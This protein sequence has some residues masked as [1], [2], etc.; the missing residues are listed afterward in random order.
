MSPE[1]G[2]HPPRRV[3]FVTGTLAEPA[4]RR[5]LADMQPPFEAQVAVMKITVAA[6]MTTAWIARLLEVPAGHRP[7]PYSRPL[8]RRYRGILIDHLECGLRRAPRIFARFRATS[9]RLRRR[10]VRQLRDRDP[11]RDQQ[12]AEAGARPIRAAADYFR[13]SGADLIDIGCTPGVPFPESATW[14]A[15]CARPACGSASTASTPRRSAPPW[16]P[17][18][19]WSSASTVP[20]WRG[21]G[22]WWQ[23]DPGGGHP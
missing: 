2:G 12:C 4:L 17:A 14:C 18:P 22:T 3:L 21:P 19:S 10:G 9:G 11:G 5:V 16:K 1:S 20:T 7:G 15:S 23:P 8:R 13:A 6:L